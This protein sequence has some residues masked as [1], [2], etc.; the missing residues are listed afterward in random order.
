MAVLALALA[1]GLEVV[2][3]ALAFVEELAPLRP[4]QPHTSR[5]P[6]CVQDHDSGIYR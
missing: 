5:L 6:L 1:L 2:A 4:P 3:L